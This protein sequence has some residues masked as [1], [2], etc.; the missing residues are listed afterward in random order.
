MRR[1][2]LYLND[3]VEAADHIAEFIAGADFPAFQSSE[4]LRSAVVQKL[5]V[6][7]EAA[8]RV[9]A[10]LTARHPEVPWPQ[11]IAFRNI[12]IHAYFG[13]DWDVVWR[14]ATNRCPVLRRQIAD[15]L[16]TE[17]GLQDGSTA[18]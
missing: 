9:S 13:I 11:I 12:L 8:A 2:R 4:M 3:V 6:I 7:G 5:G 16:A 1:E 15:I 14:A 10:D 17:S 18:R